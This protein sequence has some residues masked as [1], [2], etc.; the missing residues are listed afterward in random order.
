MA[1]PHEVGRFGRHQS[2]QFA[3]EHSSHLTALR[4]RL[5]LRCFNMVRAHTEHRPHIQE[6]TLERKS[7]EKIE[8]TQKAHF[9]NC[10]IAF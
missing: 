6:T 9:P 8:F 2:Q 1:I 4:I 10:V 3:V 5:K 7:I